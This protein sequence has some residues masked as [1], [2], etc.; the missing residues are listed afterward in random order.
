MS[1]MLIN[2]YNATILQI[3][4]HYYRTLDSSILTQ[5]ARSQLIEDNRFNLV[6]DARRGDDLSPDV[7]VDKQ[8]EPGLV[9]RPQADGSHREVVEGHV[10]NQH[11]HENREGAPGIW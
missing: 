6:D 3:N 8:Q 4:T 7:L 11:Q 9:E 5:N 2:P 10:E 1:M